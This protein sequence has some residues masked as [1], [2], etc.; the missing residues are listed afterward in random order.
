MPTLADAL[1]GARHSPAATRPRSALLAGA[2]GA[3]GAAVLEQALARGGFAR[4]QV[5]VT[6]PVA[7]AMHGFEACT[8]DSLAPRA[9]GPDTGFIVFDR[10]RHANGREAAFLRP[11]PAA[12]PALA[13]AFH[14]AGVR[15]L[16]VVL[17]HAPALLPQA[18]KHGLATLDEQAVAALDFEQL[19][20]VRSAQP[21]V[22]SGGGSWPQRVARAVLAQLQWLVPEQE[23]PVRAARLAEVVAL[24]ARRLPA[25]PPG[26]RVMPPELVW[27][28]A[29][30]ADP[31]PRL[32]AWLGVGHARTAAGSGEGST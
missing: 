32:D 3:L 24:L 2:G 19:L 25:A 28:A 18:L 12:L 22:A 1:R 17:P 9:D 26:A 16:L 20:I 27:Q 31:L 30:D 5:L 21:S 4:V 29:H 15:R 11:E 6:G 14:A 7:A 13:R 8:L 10:P 23:Q